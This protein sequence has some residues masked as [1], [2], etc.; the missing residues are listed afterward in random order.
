MTPSNVAE[1]IVRTRPWGVD[2]ASGVETE[3]GIKS[4]ELIEQFFREVRRGDQQVDNQ[5][6]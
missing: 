3:K 6:R 2:V 5:Y 1:A 4:S